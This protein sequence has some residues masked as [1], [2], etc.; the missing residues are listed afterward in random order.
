[1]K[2]FSMSDAATEY[3]DAS[4]AAFG[5]GPETF[6]N[7]MCYFHVTAAV[8]AYV[9]DQAR[10][11]AKTELRSAV[12]ADVEIL[13]QSLSI[14]EFQSKLI[15]VLDYWRRAGP[16]CGVRLLSVFFVGLG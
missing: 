10:C 2:R 16:C 7:L 8:D 9:R 15:A 6:H 14:S 12:L 5:S 11:G 1:M 4:R 13:H 3:R